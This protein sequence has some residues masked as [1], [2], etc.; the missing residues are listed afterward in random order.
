MFFKVITK[1]MLAPGKINFTFGDNQYV[2]A[3][4]KTGMSGAPTTEND[5]TSPKVRTNMHKVEL[6]VYF[7][8]S[9]KNREPTKES[10]DKAV[11]SP[12][13]SITMPILGKDRFENE[14][15]YLSLYSI[16]GCIVNLTASFPDLKIQN[17]QRKTVK[18]D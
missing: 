2:R 6:S 9:E 17:F 15:V 18:E 7:S 5:H 1:D 12:S 8:V 4:R 11:D 10:C 16:T 13:G 14:E 3:P